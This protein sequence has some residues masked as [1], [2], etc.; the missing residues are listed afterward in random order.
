MTI[1]GYMPVGL[2]AITYCPRLP[3]RYSQLNETFRSLSRSLPLLLDIAS[4]SSAQPVIPSL[5]RC[6]HARDLEVSK[7][8]PDVDLYSLHHDP[9][10]SALT[11]GS[12]FFH[13]CLGFLQGL[14]MS[15][16]IYVFS[17]LP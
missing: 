4:M 12:Q 7:L 6:L 17:P 1:L 8:A 9:G 13:L 14:C 15:P 5:H 2:P 11:A 3:F 10:I 16:D